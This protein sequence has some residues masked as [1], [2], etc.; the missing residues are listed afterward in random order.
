M[1]SSNDI[2]IGLYDAHYTV[3]GHAILNGVT[4]EVGRGEIVAVMGRSG[5]GKTT[6]LRLIV[7]L[8][9]PSAGRIAV[10][11]EDITNLPERELNPVRLKVGFVFQ[12]AA[13]FDS[14]TVYEN[15][16]FGL[17]HH[18]RLREAE[19]R[20]TVREKLHQVGLVGIEHMMPAELSGG[21]RKR[22]GVARALATEPKIMLYDE[23]TSGLDPVAATSL[24]QLIVRV[25]D[26]LGVTSLVV[27]HD[28]ASLEQSSDRAALLYDGRI[29]AV[30][31]MAQLRASGGPLVRQFLEGGLEGPIPVE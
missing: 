6:L 31:P 16:A 29:E 17:R 25:R 9:R 22:V 20:A 12:Y 21:M 26:E 18:R 28:V 23:P 7:R 15:V 3:G 8:V 2:A 11:G 10:D 13:L 30:G 19:V 27:S 24:N 5:S 14:L 1:P 4:L